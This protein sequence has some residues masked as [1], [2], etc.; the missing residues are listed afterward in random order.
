MTLRLREEEK[1]KIW[2]EKE[3]VGSK[4]LDEE[5]KLLWDQDEQQF[6]MDITELTAEGIASL[7]EVEAMGLTEEVSVCHK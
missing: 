5:D 7:G 4:R 2:L 3:K 1:L 6:V